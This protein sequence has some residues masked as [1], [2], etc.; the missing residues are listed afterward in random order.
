M[1]K[2]FNQL[3]FKALAWAICVL[4]STLAD[5]QSCVQNLDSANYFK[6]RNQQKA[7]FYANALLADLDSA[8]C[9][10]EIGIASTYN[11]TFHNTIHDV[12]FR[13]YHNREPGQLKHC[14]APEDYEWCMQ[15]GIKTKL[16]NLIYLN[17]F[18]ILCFYSLKVNEIELITL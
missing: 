1:V 14:V 12:P 3:R 17:H 8:R 4:I 15:A 5:G 9:P 13:V 16:V 18:V 10:S 2:K 7:K 11:N 6:Y